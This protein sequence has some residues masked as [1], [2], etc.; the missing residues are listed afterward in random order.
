MQEFAPV[1][2]QLTSKDKTIVFTNGCFDII[3]R[4]HCEYLFAAKR[5][6]DFL[7]VGLNT[8]ESVRRLKGDNRPFQSLDDRT[9]ILASL[10]FVDAVIPFSQDT[11][12]ELIIDIHPDIL[13]KGADYEIDEIVGAKEVI[14][15]GGKVERIP[16]V[17]GHSTTKILKKIV[18]AFTS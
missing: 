1:R 15:W 16:L 14:S 17:E 11:P 10:F 4:G 13:V 6:G 5:L 3:H 18:S 8:D 2:E 9:I 12:L 7:V